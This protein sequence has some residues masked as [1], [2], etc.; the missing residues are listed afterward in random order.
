LHL[1]YK[2]DPC[3]IILPDGKPTGRVIKMSHEELL[4]ELLA[5]KAELA[6]KRAR[7]HTI[8][9]TRKVRLQAIE[10]MKSLRL[11]H[12]EDMKR[13][14]LQHIEDMKS[15]SLQHIE[16]SK[17]ARLKNVQDTCQ[18]LENQLAIVNAL[19]RLRRRQAGTSRVRPFWN[20]NTGELWYADHLIKKFT[21]PAP[22]QRLLLDWFRRFRFQNP[23]PNPWLGNAYITSATETLKY[24]VDGLNE[25][26]FTPNLLRFG[27]EVDGRK[28]YWQAIAQNVAPST[29]T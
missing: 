7:L 16:E 19:A 12:I 10:D 17:A 6:E 21:K 25:D 11:Q 1:V 27:W 20:P 13:L 22:N 8:E 9:E 4:L 2:L 15:L 28:A 29:P 5:K 24:T 18:L 3:G 23:V 14:H 26:H